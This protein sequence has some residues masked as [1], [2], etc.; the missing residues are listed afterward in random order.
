MLCYNN[1]LF[2]AQCQH[3]FVRNFTNKKERRV[4]EK[5]LLSLCFRTTIWLD[6]VQ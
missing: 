6:L 1:T 3:F 2:A 4:S 5:T